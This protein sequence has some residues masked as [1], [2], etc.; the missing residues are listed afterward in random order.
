MRLS[1]GATRWRL[2]RQLLTESLLLVVRSAARWASS[3]ATGASN[4]CL[5]PPT[6]R[7][8]FDWRVL[9]FVLAV[10]GLTGLVFGIAPALRGTGMNVNAALKETG[11]GVVG[12]RSWASKIAPRRAGRRSRSCCSSAPGCSCGRSP[13]CA[14]STSDSTRRTCCSSASTRSSTATTRRRP[15]RSTARCSIGSAA[16]P[17]SRP[18]PC[19]LR[20]SSRAASTAPASSC[21]AAPTSPT[22]AIAT[23]A[24]TASSCRRTSSTSWASR[25]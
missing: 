14:T 3:S 4:C 12:S 7:R 8:P 22:S 13:T 17:A 10:S 19:R 16:S 2:V 5:A 18:S 15:R 9:A 20:R 23:T 6:C 11:R 1:L 24:S 21:R 25:C